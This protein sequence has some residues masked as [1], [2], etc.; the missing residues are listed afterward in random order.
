MRFE[1]RALPFPQEKE[2]SLWFAFHQDKLLIKIIGEEFSIPRLEDIR[3]LSLTPASRLYLGRLDTVPCFEAE[4]SACG[5]LPEEYVFVNPR[6]LYGSL[7]DE[8]FSLALRAYHLMTWDRNSRY[9]GRCGTKT[10]LSETEHAKACPHC[11]MTAYPKISP[12]VIVAVTKGDKL[13]LARNANFRGKFY[14]TLAGFVEPGETLEGC[15]MREIREEAGIEVKNI[16][17]FGSQPWPFPDS[18]MVGFTAEYAGGELRPDEKELS[19]AAWFGADN[20]PELPGKL[21]IARALID[22]FINK[23]NER[24]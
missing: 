9:C 14:S 7:D 22:S 11:G 2:P 16:A 10:T 24:R 3:L 20:L 21:S 12:A 6:E 5:Q 15:V 19:A 1:I 18:L 4:L 17:Y 8:L 13:L 23:F